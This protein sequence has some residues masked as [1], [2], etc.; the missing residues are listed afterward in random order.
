MDW[1]KI[2]WTD[3]FFNFAGP[4]V[5]QTATQ[6]IRIIALTVMEISLYTNG[7]T[8]PEKGIYIGPDLSKTA[9]DHITPGYHCSHRSS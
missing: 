3:E 6:A 5:H 9:N 7:D 8:Y 4:N 1:E 2:R